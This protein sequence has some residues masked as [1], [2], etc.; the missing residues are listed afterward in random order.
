MEINLEHLSEL[1]KISLKSSEKEL[2]LQRIESMVEWIGGIRELDY[3]S[4]DQIT[5]ITKKN[6]YREDEVT[7]V[8]CDV[9]S[10]A[11]EKNG[12]MFSVPS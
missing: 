3:P 2:L 12:L 11:P 6:A 1:S 7:E 8:E 9:L 5:L 10:N 4:S